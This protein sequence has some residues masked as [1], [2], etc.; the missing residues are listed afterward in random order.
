MRAG[1]LPATS[2]LLG[3]EALKRTWSGAGAQIAFWRAQFHTGSRAVAPWGI[4]EP[5]L[6]GRR[7]AELQSWLV[8]FA[9]VFMSGGVY[10]YCS[11]VPDGAGVVLRAGAKLDLALPGGNNAYLLVR[12]WA[13]TALL[14]AGVADT[15]SAEQ[16]VIIIK[17]NKSKSSSAT[18]TSPVM[19]S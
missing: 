1:P 11:P 8:Y 5:R 15:G 9:C 12:R 19:T 17:I 6:S 3:Q 7:C 18:T 14:L 13:G 4:E 10:K 16:G 2:V